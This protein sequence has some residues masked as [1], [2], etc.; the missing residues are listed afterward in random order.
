ML[1]LVC[2]HKLTVQ[3]DNYTRDFCAMFYL[4]V[5]GTEH[6]H[7]I[8]R[9]KGREHNSVLLMFRTIQDYFLAYSKIQIELRLATHIS[10][11]KKHGS[12]PSNKNFLFPATS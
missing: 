2:K 3:V 8:S 10:L 4:M 5:K 7:Q 12:R 6:E 11:I 9:S 1:S